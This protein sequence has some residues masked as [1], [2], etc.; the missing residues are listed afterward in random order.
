MAGNSPQKTAGI[1]GVYGYT[2]A[3]PFLSAQEMQG[4]IVNPAHANWGEQETPYPWEAY[5]GAQGPAKG[6]FGIENELL[7]DDDFIGGLSSGQIGDDPEGDYTPYYGSHAAPFPKGVLYK[8]DQTLS[9]KG[10]TAYLEQSALIHGT[11]TNA[12]ASRMYS[13]SL[14]ANQDDWVGFFNEVQGEDLVTD[15]DKDGQVGPSSFGFGVNDHMSNDFPKQNE[16]GFNT[17]HR[18][19]R[20]ATGHIPG[21]YLYIN[22]RGRP[23]VKTMPH[24]AL[25]AIGDNSPFSG[26]NLGDSFNIDGA[27]LQDNATSYVPPPTP[28]VAPA[29]Q[30]VSYVPELE[31]W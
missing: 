20:Y 23:M 16:Y 1:S 8:D 21:N 6:P 12:A 31:L 17:S 30:Q 19:R 13:E 2:K 28:Y 9:P 4:G 11:N 10:S 24:T 3:Q 14:L 29:T 27:I 7:G 26:D 25:P 5:G 22:A 15:T 18:H